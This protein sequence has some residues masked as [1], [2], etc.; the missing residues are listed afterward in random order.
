VGATAVDTGRLLPAE[1]QLVAAAALG[2]LCDASLHDEAEREIRADV[3]TV[4]L[5]GK[6]ESWSCEASGIS[7]AGA[8]ISGQLDLRSAKVQL[9]LSLMSCTFEEPILLTDART[10][11]LNL[12]GSTLQGLS[13]DGVQIDGD[14]VLEAV[15]C[16]E[17]VSLVHA[18]VSGYFQASGAQLECGAGYAL[19]LTAARIGGSAVLRPLYAEE[20]AEP[21][22]FRASGAGGISLAAASVGKLLDLTGAQIASNQ[23]YA[24]FGDS[25]EVG[26]AAF[27]RDGFAAT[28]AVML[29]GARIGQSLDFSGAALEGAPA[30]VT[31]VAEIR[32]S[33]LFATWGEGENA[34]PFRAKGILILSGATVGAMLDFGGAQI[35][36]EDAI[37]LIAESISV[38]GPAFLRNGFT[39]TGEVNV[40]GAT[41]GQSLDFSYAVLKNP[42]GIALQADS[43]KTSGPVFLRYVQAEGTLNFIG[44]NIGQSFDLQGA[45][46]RTEAGPAFEA[47]AIA[48]RG[49][50]Y[51]NIGTDAEGDPVP[52]RAWGGVVLIGSKLGAI[53]ATGALLANEHGW[54]LDCDTA[55]IA[56]SAAFTSSYPPDREP[57]EFTAYGGVSLV[58]ATV[59]RVLSFAGAKLA[60]PNGYALMAD[61]LEVRAAAFLR[62]G[63][64]AQGGVNLLG[65]TIGQSLDLSGAELVGP[66]EALTAESI[67]VK[68]ALHLRGIPPSQEGQELQPFRAVGTV[69]LAGATIAQSLFILDARIEQDAEA[70]AALGYRPRALVLDGARLSGDLFLSFLEP[71]QGDVSLVRARV[72]RLFDNESAWPIAPH[73]LVLDGFT[74]ESFGEGAPVDVE[75]RM[76]W[77]WRQ[78]P[79]RV[80]RRPW[81]GGAGSSGVLTQPF[82]QLA[83]VYQRGGDEKSAREVR[84]RKQRAIRDYGNVRTRERLWSRFLDWTMLYGYAAYRSLILGVLL[85]LLGWAIFAWNQDVMR[86]NSDSAPEFQPLV[87]SFDSLAP[88]IDLDQEN[89]YT[90]D[91]AKPNGD[92]VQRYL[93]LHIALGWIVTT[94]A[95]AAL[96][97]LVRRG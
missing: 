17:R 72:S 78:D 69:N 2:D 49:T 57:L 92:W 18:D 23:E 52:F 56:G 26:G 55:E 96:T 22:P 5:L 35:E 59:G 54:A 95:V 75:Q 60:N 41:F 37:A 45:S 44:A 33:M 4:L 62:N 32:G 76:D 80:K 93:W 27:L 91:S 39:A 31:Q 77:L 88:I 90:P 84:I 89:A 20:D 28:G 58:A 38:A 48:V 1:E 81:S 97:G 25:L 67:S 79:D 11:S 42:N 87:Y 46:L 9:P 51:M 14:L 40:L 74:Y 36:N 19:D 53:L 86:T 68:G 43:A 47:S 94:L 10:R 21:T 83:D 50:L 66:A 65:A 7:L 64:S 30:L 29:Y 82:E 73:R 6:N 8:T 13:G 3:L 61:A 16:G 71:P 85:L 34:Q 63:F 70:V 12:T 24:L 15:T